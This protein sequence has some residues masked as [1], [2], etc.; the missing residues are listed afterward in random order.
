MV[1]LLSPTGVLICGE[2]PSEKDLGA[3]GPPWPLP[4]QVYLNHLSRPGQELAYGEDGRFLE[5]KLGPV[6]KD[7]LK[8]IEHI[9]PKRTHPAGMTED[10]RIH[11]WISVW[12]HKPVA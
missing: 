9:R 11:D 1:E 10:G 2:W 6:S 5:D 8:R 12:K 4:P 3:G 7:G